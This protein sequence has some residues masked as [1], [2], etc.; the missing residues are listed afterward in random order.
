MELIG[1]VCEALTSLLFPFRWLHVYVPLL[2]EQL[3]DFLLSPTPFLIG[4]PSEYIHKA[5][6]IQKV[7]YFRRVSETPGNCNMRLG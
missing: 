5:A 7:R 4:I 1:F 3:T 6:Q 2:P